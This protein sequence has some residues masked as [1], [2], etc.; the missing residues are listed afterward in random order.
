MSTCQVLTF[1]WVFTVISVIF[2][3]IAVGG[4]AN[5][6][7]IIDGLNS[8]TAGTALIILAAFGV[9]ARHVGDIPSLSLA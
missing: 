2:T 3:A 8:L 9:V 4:V 7:N 5:S 6:I 1:Y